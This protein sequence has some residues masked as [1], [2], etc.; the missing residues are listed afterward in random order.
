VGVGIVRNV[1]S[2]VCEID[3]LLMGC[4]VLGRKVE[5]A[6]L[7]AI[8]KVASGQSASLLRALFVQGPRNQ[9]LKDFIIRTGFV[10]LP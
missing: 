4:R 3:S 7:Y 8:T 1:D 6:F 5:N 9:L 10:K 2:T